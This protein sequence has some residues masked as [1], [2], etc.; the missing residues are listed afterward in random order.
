MQTIDK[1]LF[2]P[3]K[4]K[5]E[6]ISLGRTKRARQLLEVI[7]RY[8]EVCETAWLSPAQ[9]AILLDSLNDIDRDDCV[10]WGYIP[11]RGKKIKNLGVL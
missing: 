11:Y 8:L 5:G 6:L 3:I 10:K 9:Y 7:D 2:F 1:S 4:P